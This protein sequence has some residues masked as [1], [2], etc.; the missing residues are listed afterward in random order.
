[1]EAEFVKKVIFSA[2]IQE[3]TCLTNTPN[4]FEGKALT[5]K[6]VNKGPDS[7]TAVQI[8]INGELW[9]TLKLD[10]AKQ[11]R[12]VLNSLNLE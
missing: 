3:I 4:A 8:S 9:V 5:Q 12:N 6:S 2:K 1:M 10:A 11:L 7:Y